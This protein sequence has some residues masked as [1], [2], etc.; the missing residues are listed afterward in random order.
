[1]QANQPEDTPL[2]PRPV[3]PLPESIITLMAEIVARHEREQ[4]TREA[5]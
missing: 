3:P 5:A 4:A 1:M 2:P